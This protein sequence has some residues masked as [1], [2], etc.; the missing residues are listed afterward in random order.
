MRL[1]IRQKMTLMIGLPAAAISLGVM[2]WL[3]AFGQ[4]QAKRIKEIEMAENATSAAAQFES[5]IGKASQV[6]DMT[7]RFMDFVPDL[8]D[9][10][11][12]GLLRDNVGLNQRIFGAALAFEPGTYKEEEVLFCPY[13]FENRAENRLSEI[14]I[15]QSVY[16]W[17]HD[18]QWEWWHLPKKL[19]RASWT[20]PYFDEGAGNILM[21]TYSAPFKRQ[22]AFGGVATVDIDLERLGSDVHDAI[23][24][25][26]EFYIL[27]KDGGVISSP[28]KGEIMTKTLTDLILDGSRGDLKAAAATIL[29]GKDGEI[30]ISGL[31]DD[32]PTMYAFAPIQSTG[33]TFLSFQDEASAMIGFKKRKYVVASIFLGSIAAMLGAIIFMSGKVARPIVHLRRQVQRVS[34]G[35]PGVAIG[36]IRTR[37][38]IEDLAKAF[39]TMQGK[40]LDREKR[41]ETARETTLNE[42]LESAPDAMIV[43]DQKGIIRRVNSKV[44]TIFG[45]S[46]EELS[47]KNISELMPARFRET[48]GAHLAAYFSEPH[49]RIMGAELELL[50]YRKDG[51]EFPIEI[52]LSPFHEPDGIMAVAAIRDVTERKEKEDELR[53]L[54]EAVEQSS[55]AVFIT[56]PDGDIEYVNARFIE[57]T[58][59]TAEE[60]IGQNPRILKSGSHDPEFYADVWETLTNGETWH[61]EF[62][63]QKKDGTLFWASAALSPIRDS[64][65]RTSHYVAIEDDITAEREAADEIRAKE[66]RFRT[67]LANLPGT[68]YRCLHDADWTMGFISDQVEDL[69]GYPSSDF[70]GNSAR[71]FD[72]VIHPDDRELVAKEVGEAVEAKAPWIVHYRIVHRDGSIHWAGERGRAIYRDSDGEADYLDGVIIDISKEKEMETQVKVA[73]EQAEEANR[74]KSDFL[75]SM[76]H[77]LRTPLNGVLGYAQILQRD[78][79]AT[80]KQKENL[81]SIINCGDHLLSLI[82]DVLDLSKIEAGRMDLDE[83]PCDL[84]QLIRSL[85][86][87]VGERARSKGL[88]F[89]TEISPEV[90][91]GI[92]TDAPKLRQILVNLLGNAVK[93]TG[94]GSVTLKVAE[95]SDGYLAFEVVDTGVGMTKE[96]AE[97]VFD[98][99]K[100]VEAGKAAGGTGLGLAICVRL[101]E[102]MGGSLSLDSEKGEGSCFRLSLPL[103][104]VEE[105]N[106]GDLD[107]ATVNYAEVKLAP[108][109]E[110]R[111]LVADDRETN[112]NILEQLLEDA[113]FEVELADDGD[114]AIDAMRRTRFDIVLMDVRMPRLNGIEAVKQVRADDALKDLPVVAV[115]A[116]VFPEFRD[117]AIEA[118]F[119]EFLPKPFRAAELVHVMQG[120]LDLEWVPIESGG[121]SLATSA[122]IDEEPESGESI[123][124]RLP[125]P[126]MERFQSALKIKNLSAL[127]ALAKELE[128][129]PATDALGK[130]ISRLA[131]SF[132]FQGLAALESKLTPGEPT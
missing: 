56:D 116:S 70:I 30:T 73:M 59:Y 6:A 90:P 62:R 18:E 96:E 51:S 49:A 11:I 19:Q 23:P 1:S 60:A 115:T 63:N 132:D 38:E 100:Q 127:N 36:E 81:T 87:I 114:T 61:G 88:D 54:N 128:T 95:K 89:I 86:D 66:E 121:D 84:N 58:G 33:W 52:G 32:Q 3:I 71:T 75:S 53:K 117:K 108:N 80:P 72:S 39:A 105:E 26:G 13:V 130:E 17:Y 94:E 120:L 10:Q 2:V 101:A 77:E 103:D 40:V 109:Q 47:G 43:A 122:S 78:K 126:L 7:A 91:R 25:I 65:G 5:Y 22:G 110:V 42:L 8:Q 57:I 79:D 12:Y 99:F 16:D 76:S 107:E 82:N 31:L 119:S 64:K 48:H 14:N 15:D 118:G 67:L 50:G 85:T 4:E 83:G 35:E 74:A 46:L 112:R 98:P 97:V 104:E 102:K 92:I 34:D 131:R 24:N 113:G 9:S 125:A 21:T 69:T 28:K 45:Y 123:D 111:V 41:L 93:F 44:A 129:S 20:K 124:Y 37:D 68:V 29:S 106:L 27:G 55:A